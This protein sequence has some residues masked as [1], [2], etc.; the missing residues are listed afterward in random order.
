MELVMVMVIMGLLMAI[1]LP[2]FTGQQTEGKVAATRA[3][4]ERLRT[5]VSLM[6]SRTLTYPPTGTQLANILIS[7]PNPYIEEIPRDAFLD[8]DTIVTDTNTP[9]GGIGGWCYNF[10]TG[11][12]HVNLPDDHFAYG[13]VTWSEF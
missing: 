6:Y 2:N 10:L 12:I 8:N 5:A 1:I 3:N 13:R 4:L 11:D 7:G 9:C